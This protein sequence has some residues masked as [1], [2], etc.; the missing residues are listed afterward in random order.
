MG[1][2][3]SSSGWISMAAVVAGGEEDASDAGAE[4]TEAARKAPTRSGWP[5]RQRGENIAN[6]ELGTY[7]ER[8][9]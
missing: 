4:G 5:S 1:V 6:W 7:T 9:I 3:E 2:L 8:E